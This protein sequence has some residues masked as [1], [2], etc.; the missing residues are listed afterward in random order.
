MLLRLEHLD[1]PRYGV[2]DPDGE[3]QLLTDPGRPRA[4]TTLRSTLRQQL[5]EDVIP[6]SVLVVAGPSWGEV[7]PARRPGLLLVNPLAQSVSPPASGDLHRAQGAYAAGNYTLAI[8]YL[9]RAIQSGELDSA[10]LAEAYYDR[11]VAYSEQGEY[12]RALA[13]Y[14]QA[15][16]LKP[17][18]TEAAISLGALYN[19]LGEY[20]RAVTT[21]TA[22]IQSKPDAADAHY[23]RG[24]AYVAL[25]EFQQALTDYNRAL[26]LEPDNAET[27][28]NRGNVYFMLGQWQPAVADYTQAIRLNP[29]HVMAYNNRGIAYRALEQHQRAIADYDRAIRL[30]PSCTGPI[31]TVAT[32]TAPWGNGARRLPTTIGPS[33][34]IPIPPRPTTIGGW[35]TKPWA[36]RGGRKKI[37]RSRRI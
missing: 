22:I 26:Q 25:G 15:L 34:S 29:R 24:N 6:P 12:E 14:Q 36:S 30:A 19:A 8:E 9:G 13:D 35:L 21:F 32:P 37:S 1:Q 20:A 11:G 28:Y 18:F 3:G 31:T 17:D 10:Q 4:A 23:N 33:A 16:N 2:F 5:A 27:Y 7:P